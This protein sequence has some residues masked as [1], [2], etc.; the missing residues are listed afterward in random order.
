MIPITRPPAGWQ[1]SGDTPSLGR[2]Y[3]SSSFGRP[4]P[5]WEVPPQVLRS[6]SKACPWRYAQQ[7]SVFVVP[8]QKPTLL[9]LATLRQKSGAT[10]RPQGR[11]VCG[12]ASSCFTGNGQTA[13]TGV[14][15]LSPETVTAL[16][17]A[18]LRPAGADGRLHSH[19]WL[20]RLESSRERELSGGTPDRSQAFLDRK[21]RRAMSK[22]L[23]ILLVANPSTRQ[24]VHRG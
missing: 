10:L 16:G 23:S 4:L 22:M 5:F 1:W 14:V 19:S 18:V 7:C 17:H 15:S 6:P 13:P 20:W 3:S 21:P 2:P 11:R 8:P 12:S 9:W 24:A